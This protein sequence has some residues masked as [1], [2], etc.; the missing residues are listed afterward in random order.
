M[1]KLVQVVSFIMVLLL[2]ACARVPLTTSEQDAQAKQFNAPP[3]DQAGLYVYREKH[4]GGYALRK[5]I[6]IDGEEIGSLVRGTFLYTHLPAG[7]HQISTYSQFG[8]NHIELSMEGGKNYFVR[9]KLKMG[10]GFAGAELVEVSESQG[11]RDI[12]SLKRVKTRY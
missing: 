12:S 11:K 1:R 9:Q 2:T 6:S 8:K 4:F 5:S 7:K 3:K 10:I